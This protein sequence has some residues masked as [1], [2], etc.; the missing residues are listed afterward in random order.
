MF[1]NFHAKVPSTCSEYT[2]AEISS[3][4]KPSDILIEVRSSK[5][6]GRRYTEMFIVG[7]NLYFSPSILRMIKSRRMRL[8][9]HVARMERR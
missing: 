4:L 9:G 1:T 3:I 5:K 8:A 6:I 7:H 2:A